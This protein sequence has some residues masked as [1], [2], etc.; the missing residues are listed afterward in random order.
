MARGRLAARFARGEGLGLGDSAVSGD[1]PGFDVAG[2][3]PSDCDLRDFGA[4][5]PACAGRRA[6]FGTLAGQLTI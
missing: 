2:F 1:D 3:S 5:A 4:A 6:A